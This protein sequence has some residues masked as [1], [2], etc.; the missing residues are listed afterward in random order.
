L[1]PVEVDCPSCAGGG[2]IIGDSW[3]V[4]AACNGNGKA[5]LDGAPSY[6]LKMTLG[7]RRLGEIVTLGNGDRGRIVRH[8]KRDP[9]TTSIALIGDFDGTESSYPT[10]YPSVVGVLSVSDP[11]WFSDD[12]SHAHD[13]SDT[14]DPLRGKAT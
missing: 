1:S 14:T 4:C 13:R 12:E 6:G 8:D 10:S 9:R 3:T 7:S 5:W 2:W 11:R